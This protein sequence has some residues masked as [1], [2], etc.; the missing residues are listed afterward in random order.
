MFPLARGTVYW[1]PIMP[2]TGQTIAHFCLLEKLGA[3]GMGVVCKARDV[4]LNRLVALK[5]LAPTRADDADMRSRLLR[6]ARAASALNHP[7]IVT[8]YE[9]GSSEDI[10]FIAMEYV[11]GTTLACR[12]PAEG[13][14]VP[15]AIAIARSIAA[16][17]A[18][19]HGAGIVHRDLKPGN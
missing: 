4:Q 13:M 10:D 14:P 18:A 8:I 9:A 3:G 11:E 19:A 1:I 12:I 17:L 2:S 7:N 15:E 5:V 16:A 6:E